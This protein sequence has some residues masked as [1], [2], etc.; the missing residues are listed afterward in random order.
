MQARFMIEK[1]DEIVATMKLTMPVKEWEELRDQLSSKWPSHDFS[2]AINDLLSQAR[3]V[4]Y[5][6]VE[7]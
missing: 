3:K 7:L 5:P 4:V 1:P 2:R 6:S